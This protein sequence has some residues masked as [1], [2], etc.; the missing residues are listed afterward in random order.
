MLKSRKEIEIQQKKIFKKRKSWWYLRIN[1]TK[2]LQEER[3]L[4]S[5]CLQVM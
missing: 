2:I 4:L 1:V 3:W 5:K